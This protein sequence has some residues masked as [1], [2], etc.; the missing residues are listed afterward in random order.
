M[1]K[2]D[3]NRQLL[4]VM[5]LLIS[6]TL[7]F[8]VL[9][10]EP[11]EKNISLSLTYI[12]PTGLAVSKPGPEN[13]KI[14]LS[15][16]RVLLSNFQKRPPK[17]YVDLSKSSKRRK[18][19]RIKTNELS[20]PLPFGVEIMDINPLDFK[21]Q[22]ERKIKKRV[23]MKLVL[24]G[25]LDKDLKLVT[26]KMEPE[27]V[28]ISGP[29]SII[30]TIAQLKTHPIDLGQLQGSGEREVLIDNL[31]P[32]VNLDFE[33]TLKLHYDIR[34]NKANLTLKKIKIRFL[35]SKGKI[36]SKMQYAS[37]DVLIPKEMESRLTEKNIKVIAEIP[38]KA[39]GSV[40]VPLKADLPDGVHMVKIN[41]ERI[42][43]VV[44]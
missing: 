44:P 39:R 30:K 11:I 27:E 18:T 24:L 12:N 1:K 37:I 5:A 7:W 20:I 29:H 23:P 22:L 9:S 40:W 3:V 34:P 26:K 15:G 43:V 33:G 10:G 4:K 2:V 36:H 38:D 25:E 31:D 41:P 35:S 8:Y 16:P 14:K 6:T 21:V 13:L 19:I 28:M 42:N 17:V 32:R